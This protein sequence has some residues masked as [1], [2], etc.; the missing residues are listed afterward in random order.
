MDAISV[1]T[2]I[3]QKLADSC[4]ESH[5]KMAAQASRKISDMKAQ[6]ELLEK[7]EDRAYE[8]MVEGILDNE[9]YKRQVSRIRTERTL[10]NNEIHALQSQLSGAY[11]ETAHSIIE[12]CKEAKSLYLSRSCAERADFLKKLV[13]NPLVSGTSVQ[14]DLRKPFDVMAKIN[15]NERPDT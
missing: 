7:R 4:N 6:L 12:L 14:F 9:G 8:D 2:D 3:A 10:L 5:K 13:S 15:K 1:T 11:R